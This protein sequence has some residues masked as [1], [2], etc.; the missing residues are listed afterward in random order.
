MPHNQIVNNPRK[1]DM[2]VIHCTATPAGRDVTVGDIDL[3]HRR[4]G[5]RMVGYHYVVRLDGTV[6][7][8]RREAETGA[9]CRGR[10]ARSIGVAYVGGIEAGGRPVDTRTPSQR[11][12]LLKLLRELKRRYPDAVICGHRDFAAKACPCFDAAAEYGDLSAE[13][14]QP[15]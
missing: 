4:R 14:G 12:A 2:I 15:Q 11:E 9:H 5:F 3:W 10:N 7:R 1:V 8:G 13:E 6:E